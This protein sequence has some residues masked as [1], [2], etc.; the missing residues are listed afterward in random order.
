MQNKKIAIIEDELIICTELSSALKDSG[1]TITGCFSSAEE[2][3]V[4]IKE[5]KPDL[6]I[7]DIVLNGPLNG[8]EAAQIIMSRFDIPVVYVTSYSDDITVQRIRET[9]PSGYIIKPFTNKE[10]TET[11]ESAF[12]HYRK[13]K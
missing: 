3:I 1:Y 5:E 12:K 2:G 11:V 6:V 13:N 7:I 10:L 8:I 9:N 4:S